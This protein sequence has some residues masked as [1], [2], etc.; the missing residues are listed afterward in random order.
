MEAIGRLETSVST[1]QRSVTSQK[2]EGVNL[3]L[4][5]DLH[6]TPQIW[7][8]DLVKTFFAFMA[9]DSSLSR[10]AKPDTSPYLDSD[11][12]NSKP[13]HTISLESNPVLPYS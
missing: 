9:L 10:S 2:N 11:D 4:H 6:L 1:N 13:Q 7:V 12:S 3:F 8:I 5:N